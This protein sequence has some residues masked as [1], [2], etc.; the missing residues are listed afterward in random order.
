VL[1]VLMADGKPVAMNMGMRSHSTLEI[2]FP[3]YDPQFSGYSPGRI[4]LLRLAQSARAEG[5]ATLELGR[6]GALYKQRL[7]NGER[8]QAVGCV[9]LHPRRERTRTSERL[10]RGLPSKRVGRVLDRLDQRRW[11]RSLDPSRAAR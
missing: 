8:A 9:S 10:L 6:S 3:T 11:W 7:M 5:L 2:W 4:L 1:S